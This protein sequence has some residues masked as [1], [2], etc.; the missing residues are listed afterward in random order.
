MARA[1]IIHSSCEAKRFL[2]GLLCDYFVTSYCTLFSHF[3]HFPWK[4]L[5]RQGLLVLPMISCSIP[6]RKRPRFCMYTCTLIEFNY[7]L[8]GFLSLAGQIR[9]EWKR[10]RKKASESG[11]P[12]SYM[13][14]KSGKV[15]Q[16]EQFCRTQCFGTLLKAGLKQKRNHLSKFCFKELL[17]VSVQD[18]KCVN[19]NRLLICL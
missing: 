3:W 6:V 7:D 9:L 4:T 14:R 8:R 2:K 19:T 15:G 18:G 16:T 12:S 11:W 13:E 1:D 17:C 5:W 10:R